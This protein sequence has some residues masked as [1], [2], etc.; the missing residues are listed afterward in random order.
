[1]TP[2]LHE[3]FD[4]VD[5]QGRALGYCW[6]LYVQV[7]RSG[8]ESIA[9]LNATAS[10]FFAIS[11]R[12]LEEQ[13]IL[14]IARLFDS[15]GN[16]HQQNA[17]L[18]QL[19]DCV[20]QELG[21]EPAKFLRQ[22]YER[23]HPAAEA[24]VKHRHKLLAH[25]DMSVALNMTELPDVTVREIKACLA[26]IEAILNAVRSRLDLQRLSY[27]SPEFE[28]GGRDLLKALGAATK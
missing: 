19:A 6:Q 3:V 16:V 22:E 8:G 23:V 9:L 5:R 10:T 12:A 18:L 25:T 1:M 24:I 13:I 27:M 17:S 26:S 14:M 15:V 28:G 11:G 2:N 21:S 20:K 4:V 7:Y